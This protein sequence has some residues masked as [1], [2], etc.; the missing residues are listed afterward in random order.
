VYPATALGGA[1]GELEGIERECKMDSGKSFGAE[2]TGASFAVG[3]V[4]TDK[5]VRMPASRGTTLDPKTAQAYTELLVLTIGFL[6]KQIERAGKLPG[7]DTRRHFLRAIEAHI[8]NE[9]DARLQL[10]AVSRSAAASASRLLFPVR[11]T[12]YPSIFR[13]ARAALAVTPLPLEVAQR[14]R[15]PSPLTLDRRQRGPF[16]IPDLSGCAFSLLA[17]HIA[18]LLPDTPVLLMSFLID[19]FPNGPIGAKYIDAQRG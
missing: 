16:A 7:A 8:A 11:R 3:G 10:R 14:L 12:L 1:K 19:P 5:I 17:S 4:M 9:L 2:E 18:P 13:P 15:F 6:D